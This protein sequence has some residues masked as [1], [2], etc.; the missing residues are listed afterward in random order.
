MHLQ[1]HTFTDPSS[2]PKALLQQASASVLYCIRHTHLGHQTPAG[3]CFLGTVSAFP[4]IEM[5]RPNIKHQVTHIC[6]SF[7]CNTFSLLDS[8]AGFCQ[9]SNL[10]WSTMLIYCPLWY[11]YWV[12]WGCHPKSHLSQGFSNSTYWHFKLNNSLN[13]W[14]SCRAFSSIKIFSR[15][16]TICL[17]IREGS[18]H[19][20]KT[21]NP[22]H[23]WPE[24]SMKDIRGSFQIQDHHQF[25]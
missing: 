19:I 16:F 6:H 24:A 4:V 12:P 3:V 13:W 17:G 23:H 15:H 22:Y 21:N 18:P 10:C 2:S 14:F 9:L 5:P 1:C 11:Y 20:W 8:Q 25:W 7:L